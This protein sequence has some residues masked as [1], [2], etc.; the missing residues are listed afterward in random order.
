MFCTNFQYSFVTPRELDEKPKSVKF[1]TGMQVG[2]AAGV[3]QAAILTNITQYPYNYTFFQ[4]NGVVVPD[5]LTTAPPATANITDILT[6]ALHFTTLLSLL[7]STGVGAA[8]ATRETGTGLVLF[9]PSDDAFA[10]L[11]AGALAKLTAAEKVA[12]LQYHALTAYAPLGSL[13]KLANPVSTT[14]ATPPTSSS[15]TLNISALAANV[16][17]STGLVNT[18][19]T[20]TLYDNPPVAVFSIGAVLLPKELFAPG[21]VGAPVPSPIVAP[22]LAP[23][24]SLLTPPTP[25]PVPFALPSTPTPTPTPAFTPGIAPVLAPSAATPALVPVTSP[26]AP[27][28]SAPLADTS[29]AP[30]G[31]PLESQTSPN[32]AEGMLAPRGFGLVVAAL[33]PL[34]AAYSSVL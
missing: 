32:A 31:S 28:A 34:V 27:P 13:E 22:S 4:V 3:M 12:L 33:L 23:A 5:G 11:P 15:F 7:E 26:P 10:A 14:L 30:A 2:T 16:A 20:N 21:P 1:T 29:Y 8:L 17:I 6:K 24:P 9:A 19:V 18:S 25:T